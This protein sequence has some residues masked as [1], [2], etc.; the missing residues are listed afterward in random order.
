[1]R[2]QTPFN[3]PTRLIYMLRKK[4]GAHIVLSDLSMTLEDMLLEDVSVVVKSKKIVFGL[5]LCN[6]CKVTTS[7]SYDLTDWPDIVLL[8]QMTRVQK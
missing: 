6:N 2:T 5:V 4:V 8:N 7:R 1:M 3:F